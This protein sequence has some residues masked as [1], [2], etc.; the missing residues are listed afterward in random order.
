M[1]RTD[2]V[3]KLMY[4]SG[5]TALA[6]LS[7]AEKPRRY[8]LGD[9]TLYMR[10]AHYIVAVGTDGRPTI[11]ELAQR[12]RVTHGAVAQITTRLEKKGYIL[13][14]KDPSDRRQTVVSLT[15]KG[16]EVCLT[17]IA[18]D[19]SEYEWASEFL[20]EFSDEE[21][22]RFLYYEQKMREIYTIRG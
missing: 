22:E 19:R 11:G 1:N 21:L 12:L 17:H 20:A 2:L 16:R 9:D 8:T 7:F 4:A 15:E 13:R 6:A 18:Y 14:S 3:E 5:Q 10:E